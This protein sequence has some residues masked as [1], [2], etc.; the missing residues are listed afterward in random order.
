[1]VIKTIE[2]PVKSS[3]LKMSI[4]ISALVGFIG[5]ILFGVRDC[6]IVILNHAPRP[7]PLSEMFFFSLYPIALYALIGCLSMTVGGIIT[8]M[9]LQMGGYTVTKTKLTGL[10]VGIF[11]TL[12]VSLVASDM[13]GLKA[14]QQNLSIVGEISL[15]SILCGVALGGLTVYLV[16]KTKKEELIALS[17]SL[18]ISALVF[19]YSV[20]WMNLNLLSGFLN[21]V[22]LIGYGGLLLLISTLAM[23]VYLL[24]H[25]VVQKDKSKTSKEKWAAF[26]LLGIVALIC[27]I[28]SFAVNFNGK[29]MTN[30]Q[31]TVAPT[32]NKEKILVDLKDKPNILWIVMDTV[33]ADHLSSYGYYRKTTPN[34][35]KLASE[36][37]LFENAI[38]PAPWTLPSHASMFTGMF[39]SKHGSDAE[40]LYLEDKFN[41][42][43]E[44]LRSYGYRTF[45][46]SNNDFVS[47]RTNLNQ[48]FDNFVIVP[49]DKRA[50]YELRDHLFINAAVNLPIISI[51]DSGADRT[52]KVVKKWIANNCYTKSPFFIFVN[53]MEAHDPYGNTPYSR[54]YLKRVS[55][56][57]VKSASR[58]WRGYLW[59]KLKFSDNDFDILS[60]LYDGDI[61]YLDYKI[62]E[63]INYL[64]KLKILDNTLLIITSDHGENFG[65]HNFMNHV[66]N[67]YDTLLHVPLIIRYPKVFSSNLK[68]QAQ[69]QTTDIFPTILDILG[70]ELTGENEIQGHSLVPLVKNK[71][72][73]SASFAVSEHAIW[74]WVLTQFQYEN[75][76]FDVSEYTRRLKCIRTDE[77]KY[78]WA[79]DGRDEL[80]N[81][82]KDP[83]ELHNLIETHHKEAMEL[84]VAMIDWLV[85]FKNY[86]P[87]TIKGTG[88]SSKIGEATIKRL[89]D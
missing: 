67:V 50:A 59:G 55:T 75:P 64:K 4:G 32:S 72:R 33:R 57:E 88:H 1:M 8:V 28:V 22:S 41:T 56:S 18:F 34:I 46:Y 73:R 51:K 62:G 6:I 25:F 52:N 71:Q 19:L 16:D 82:R 45:G 26:I 54:H 76:E 69:V 20:L 14:I 86:R 39:P 27:V 58:D 60:S 48:G 89:R 78:I 87:Q 40:H 36:G 17:I 37:I 35:D 30:A 68:L 23:G 53:Y 11:S 66:L 49:H 13:V 74:N 83:G 3:G 21:P 85:S 31:T 5:G 79:S 47:P 43:S 15:V 2:K 80:Y 44:V 77:F 61:L 84:R 29:N 9:F 65:E 10:Y 70:I 24:S 63:L 42:I 7:F 12:A 81:I 38:S